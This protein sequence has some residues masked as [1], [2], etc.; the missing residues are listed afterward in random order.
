[1]L[2]QLLER[3]KKCLHNCDIPM[4]NWS[5]L[6][7]FCASAPSTDGWSITS[8]YNFLEPK[9]TFL[10]CIQG[11][12]ARIYYSWLKAD[13]QVNGILE[14]LIRSLQRSLWLLTASLNTFKREVAVLKIKAAINQSGWNTDDEVNKIGDEFRVLWLTPPHTNVPKPRTLL[15]LRK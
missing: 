7:L 3:P 15:R 6:S 8:L 13:V 11:P 5:M 12:Q 1:M 14:T 2:D 9:R 10:G 4:V